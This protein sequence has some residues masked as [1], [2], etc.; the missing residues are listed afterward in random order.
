MNRRAEGTYLAPESV[1]VRPSMTTKSDV[2]ALGCVLSVVFA[3]LEA[4]AA[5]VESYTVARLQH[6]KSDDYDRFFVRGKFAPSELHPE[7]KRWHDHLGRQASQRSI[8]EG[9]IVK[10][11]LGNLEKGPLEVDQDKRCDAKTVRR[12]LANT[13]KAYKSLADEHATGDAAS[14]SSQLPTPT[15]RRFH[16]LLPGLQRINSKETVARALVDT[17]HLSST[18][19]F[20][21]CEISPDGTLVA[22]WTDTKIALY[23]SQSLSSGNAFEATPAS[24]YSL[25][26]SENSIW[27]SISLTEKH[28]IAS[29]T[30]STFNVSHVQSQAQPISMVP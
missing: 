16:H 25:G 15:P 17:W 26:E 8:A 2:W 11:I 22:Y 21:G 4:G 29:T 1:S 10:D 9:R 19:D 5:G 27:K 6:N 12:M 20:K 24:D 3:Y 14:D 28:L 7:V 23:T 13:C 18:E 30:G